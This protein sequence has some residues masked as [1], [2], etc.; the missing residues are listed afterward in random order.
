MVDFLKEEAIYLF[1]VAFIMVITIIVTTRPFMP[2]KSRKIGIP[3]VFS[4]LTLLL[5]SHY[6]MRKANMKEVREAFEHNKTI[7]CVD[8]TNR[9][10]GQVV[11][12]KQ[13]DWKLEGDTF[14]HPEF[15]RGYNIRQCIVE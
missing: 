6:F 13:A 14:M 5:V 3:L 7:L 4:I 10:S 1:I 11:I 2:P 9:A 12:N 8:K 15:P